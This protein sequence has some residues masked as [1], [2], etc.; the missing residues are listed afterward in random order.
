MSKKD[1]ALF[2][3]ALFGYKRSDVNDYIRK[4]DISHAEQLSLLQ[5]EKERLLARAQ[6]A[7]AR[8]EQLEKLSVN[9]NG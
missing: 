2:S 9:R 3:G 4:A 6:K 1:G 5:A 8:V 7:E